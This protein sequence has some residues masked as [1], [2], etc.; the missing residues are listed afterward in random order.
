[1]HEQVDFSPTFSIIA[2]KLKTDLKRM[3]K[4]THPSLHPNLCF[5]KV[6][7]TSRQTNA[8]EYQN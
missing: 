1:M 5:N 8:W 2:L 4:S 7:S 3:Q 6:I